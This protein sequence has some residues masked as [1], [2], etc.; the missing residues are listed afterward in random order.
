MGTRSG[1]SLHYGRD[2]PE[3]GAAPSIVLSKVAHL[4]DG[5]PEAER[6]GVE[7]SPVAIKKSSERD[8]VLGAG[9]PST[10]VGMT[11]R[12]ECLTGRNG[13]KA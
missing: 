8:W 13:H 9:D 12:F 10:A 4:P 1:R 7:G 2:D 11:C 5:H 6:S 3:V